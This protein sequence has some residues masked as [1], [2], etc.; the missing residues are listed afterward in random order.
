MTDNPNSAELI[1]NRLNRVENGFHRAP[2]KPV[3]ANVVHRVL[4]SVGAEGDFPLGGIGVEEMSPDI[5][6]QRMI[7]G[8]ENLVCE[9]V[10]SRTQSRQSTS[11]RS[12]V[13]SKMK[14]T[15]SADSRSIE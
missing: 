3:V 5:G 2:S 15:A 6:A 4:L 14:A 8:L 9:R 7:G 11:W 13:H 1:A 12:V 10:A